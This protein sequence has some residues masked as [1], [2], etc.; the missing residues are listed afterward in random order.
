MELDS[1]KGN[2]S[3]QHFVKLAN[4]AKVRNAG[5]S[6]PFHSARETESENSNKTVKN[7]NLKRGNYIWNEYMNKVPKRNNNVLGQNFDSYA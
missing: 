7:T 3:W 6:V 1:I 5:F 2:I 4:A